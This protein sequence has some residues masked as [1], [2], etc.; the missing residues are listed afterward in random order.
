MSETAVIDV[1]SHGIILFV[2]TFIDS[3]RIYVS[4]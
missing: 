1:L 4:K 2:H 3:I